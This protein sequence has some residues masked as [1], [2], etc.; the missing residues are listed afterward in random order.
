MIKHLT[1][2]ERPSNSPWGR[3]TR[4]FLK[5]LLL[6][7]MTTAF[8]DAARAQ[9]YSK[10]F[11]FSAGYS[12]GSTHGIGTIHGQ[13]FVQ[14]GLDFGF[15][16]YRWQNV[17]LKYKVSLIPVAFVHGDQAT[18][19]S[20]RKRTVYA[21]GAD[22]ISLQF[23][24][25]RHRRFEPFLTLTGGFLYFTEQVPVIDSSRYNFTFSGGG[26]GEYMIGRNSIIIGYRYHHISNKDTGKKNP[27]I[28]SHI[29]F[30]GFSFKR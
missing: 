12:P 10:E 23:N 16:L 24:F 27:G 22:P 7:A 21:G 2:K 4:P 9:D 8:V 26:G 3:I 17:Y 20:R 13:Q 6:A 29:L 28:D 30:M 5:A 1:L 25:N 18:L 11:G 15:V 14:A 19:R